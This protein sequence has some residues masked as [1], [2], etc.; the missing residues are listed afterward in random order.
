[1]SREP[2]LI[3]IGCEEI[4]ARMI[5]GAAADLGR[6]VE[7]LLD[8]A[9]LAHDACTAWGGSRR[10]TVRVEQVEAR[11][12]DREE[13]VLGPPAQIA[14]DAQNRPTDAAR[15]FARKQGVE[16]EALTL[17]ET[18]RGGYAGFRRNV[19]GRTVGELLAAELPAVVEGMTFPKTMRWGDG[20]RRWVRPVHRVLALHGKEVLPL[21]LFGVRASDLS[22]GHRFRGRGEVRVEHPDGYAETLEKAFVLVDP[23][24]RRRRIAEALQTRAAELGGELVADLHLLDEVADLV[25]WPGVVPGSFDAGFLELPRELLATTLR[26]HQKCFS[27]ADEEG[28]PLPFFLA[29]ANTDRDPA[30]HVRRGNEWVVGGRLEDARFFWR[31]DRKAPLA[32]L[33]EELHRVVFHAR[34]GS[35]A[36]KALRMERIAGAIAGCLGLDAATA[37]ECRAAA[38]L[39]KNDLVTGTV[40]EF[41][42]LQGRVGGLM[43]REE[44]A[45]ESVAAAVYAHY[46][47][48]GPEDD[49]PPTDAAGVVAVADKLDSVVEL[50]GAGEKPSGSR[51]PFG[52]R[53]AGAGI[54]RILAE[55]DWTAT[56]QDLCEATD[57]GP[58]AKRFLEERLRA[59]LRDAGYSTNEILAVMRPRVSE[60]DVYTWTL[61][62]ILARLEAIK[63][64]RGREDFRH[65]V[66]LTERVDNILTKDAAA[67]SAIVE[68]ADLRGEYEER[69]EAAR[70]L[71]GMVERF[72]PQMA[73]K[74]EE[75]SYDGVVELL[76]EFIDPV[77]TFFDEVLV[78]DKKDP[79]ATIH[80]RELLA[81]LRDVLTRYFDIR[82]LAGQAER[83]E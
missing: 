54:I 80:R 3:E 37:E 52:L 71:A 18:D 75:K 41:P 59:Y 4:P 79:T 5:P 77:E 76:S 8:G 40:G 9:G 55:R 28:R 39:A 68:K 22:A 56:L 10:L 48:Q 44:G 38:R 73:A 23:A 69:K 16:P 33:T 49:V 30:G 43:L 13:T 65:L 29:V 82:E 72:A 25:E 34:C 78:V 35:Y 42:E 58:E 24:E 27:V 46:Q 66:K 20:T 1:M 21:E 12:R 2:L 62:D 57:P 17:V 83:R 67:L 14:F 51:D 61:H 36:D 64:V 7:A 32:G 47:P 60:H 31:E 70:A 50:L 11:Q 45:P 26:H 53:R 19:V 81:K 15:G 6:R 74:S 63:Q